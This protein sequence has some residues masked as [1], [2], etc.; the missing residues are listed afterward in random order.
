MMLVVCLPMVLLLFMQGRQWYVQHKAK[1]RLERQSLH[2]L[3][4]PA[5]SV[6]WEKAGKEL[7]LG[8]RLFDVKSVIQKSDGLLVTGLYDEEETAIENFLASH[9][10]GSSILFRLLMAAQLFI[11]VLALMHF[12]FKAAFAKRIY[13]NLLSQSLLHPPQLILTPPPQIWHTS[14]VTN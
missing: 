4:V 13:S 10:N 2:Q 7:R 9:Q 1:E 5:E 3:F 6:V 11:G 12:L 8:K 14:Y